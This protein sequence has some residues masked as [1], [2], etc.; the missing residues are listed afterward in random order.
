MAKLHLAAISRFCGELKRRKVFKVGV[1]YAVVGWLIIQIGAN[2]F[3]ALRLPEWALPLVIVITAVGFPI[4]LLI[5]WSVELTPKGLRV[6]SAALPSSE[7]KP[8]A[9]PVVARNALGAHRSARLQRPPV[10]EPAAADAEPGAVSPAR[11]SISQLRHDLRTPMNAIL[12]YGDVL[13][14]EAKELGVE[15]LLPDLRALHAD[16][17]RL[18]E[19]INEAVPGGSSHADTDDGT[20]RARAHAAVLAP[21]REFLAA[22]ESLSARMTDA[23]Q[24]RQDVD[25][26]VAAARKLTS[27]VEALATPATT[28]GQSTP[29][30]SVE[31]TLRRLRPST[32]E[33]A[34][35]GGNLLVVDDNALNRDVLTR[36]LVREGYRVLAVGSGSEALDMLRLHDFDLILLDV[37]MPQMDG[38]QVLERIEQDA[39]YA[40]IPVIMMSALDEIGGAAQCLNQ[41]A[42][43]FLIKPF[44][45]VLLR[46]RVQSSLQIRYLRSD[47]RTAEVSLEEHAAAMQRLARSIAP[48]A[49]VDALEGRT[50][51]APVHYPEVTAV[52]ARFG[53]IEALAARQPANIP[54]LLVRAVG[55]CER[56]SAARGFELTR[57]GDRGF[58]AIAGAT[59][60]S[61]HH[62]EAAAELALDI[63]RSFAEEFTEAAFG[64]Q[65]GLHTGVLTTG[66]VSG[67]K[68]VFGLWGDAVAT[69][70]AIATAASLGEVLLSNAT[71]TKLGTRF[72]LEHASVLDVPG[73]GRLPTRKLKQA[74]G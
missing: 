18:L 16:A 25:R 74:Q 47:L 7:S 1:A 35:R 60:W 8:L 37:V 52:V 72:V 50:A 40:D 39:G 21:A 2:T 55:I 5:A 45:P 61:E 70:E 3:Q 53:G 41:G 43:D 51:P 31:Q 73:G 54:A 22:A 38:M 30:A 56:H 62:A 27:L 49:L 67:D 29:S 58:T 66:L 34:S 63:S 68:V 59:V 10:R 33:P 23:G 32:A 9:A 26:L 71:G 20:V 12:G 69:A 11:V 48:A 15:A 14:Q 6:E 28:S 17:D 46:A 57:A 44:D 36:Q 13:V 42:A 24:A 65:I 19:R 4:A 64:A